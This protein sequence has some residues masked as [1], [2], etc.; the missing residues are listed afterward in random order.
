MLSVADEL[1]IYRTRWLASEVNL[2]LAE[3]EKERLRAIIKGAEI[4][5][6]RDSDIDGAMKCLLSASASK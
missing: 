4:A 1:D 2:R 5:L 6:A 3:A